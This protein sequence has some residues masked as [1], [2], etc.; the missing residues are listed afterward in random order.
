MNSGGRA[1]VSRD[2]SCHR[3]QDA[4]DHIDLIEAYAGGAMEYEEFAARALRRWRGE[5][6]DGPYADPDVPEEWMDGG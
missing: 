6:E 1:A 2:S 4:G 3:F 5:N